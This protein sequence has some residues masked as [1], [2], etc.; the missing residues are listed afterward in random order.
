MQRGVEVSRGRAVEV[1]RVEGGS[2]GARAGRGRQRLVG[3]FLVGFE[4]G[5]SL[6]A[7]VFGVFGSTVATPGAL[8]ARLHVGRRMR[9]WMGNWSEDMDLM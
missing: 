1:E 8:F 4:E 7:V 9:G 3:A 2:C 5:D 6:G